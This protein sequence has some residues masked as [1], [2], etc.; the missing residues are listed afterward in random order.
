MV[1]LKRITTLQWRKHLASDAGV[2]GM[3][4]LREKEPSITRGD[5][6]QM[7]FDAGRVEGYKQAIN[8]ISEL[9]TLEVQKEINPENP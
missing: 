6:F 8:T 3:L 4:Y 2:E 7:I 9:L 1:D 5:Q